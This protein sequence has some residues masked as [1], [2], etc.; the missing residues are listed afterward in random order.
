MNSLSLPRKKVDRLRKKTALRIKNEIRKKSPETLDDEDI[1]RLASELNESFEKVK[2]FV[3]RHKPEK[4]KVNY[5]TN[6]DFIIPQIAEENNDF[7]QNTSSEVR[8]IS[9]SDLL[10]NNKSNSLE[11]DQTSSVSDEDDL[12]SINDEDLEKFLLNEYLFHQD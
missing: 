9:L 10:Y 1:Q 5:D 12:V 8:N 3:K 11:E 6:K 4:E 7:P 2:K